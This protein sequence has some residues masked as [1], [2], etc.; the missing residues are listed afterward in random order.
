MLNKKRAAVWFLINVA[1]NFRKISQAIGFLCGLVLISGCASQ[2]ARTYDEPY[3]R[4][5]SLFRHAS[6]LLA[7]GDYEQAHNLYHQ[8]IEKYPKHPYTDDAVYRIAYIRVIADPDN[9]YF[10]Y[11]EARILFRNF[12]EKYQNSHYITACKNWLHVLEF[13]ASA[14]KTIHDG[15]ETNYRKPDPG[16]QQIIQQLREDNAKLRKDLEQLQKALER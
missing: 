11:Q 12:I 8:F 2:T 9:P 14:G 10:D 13:S 1:I 15:S 4:E 5:L 16:D 6:G 7:A 3:Y